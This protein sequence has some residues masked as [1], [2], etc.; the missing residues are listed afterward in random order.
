[1]KKMLMILGGVFLVLIIV[2]SGVL[3]W[4]QRSGS[5]HQAKFFEAVLSDDPKRVVVLF[6]PALCE[7]VD[8]PILAAWM[9]AF[10]RN[11]GALK[12]LSKT[13]F[14]TTSKI[15]NGATV[16][17]SKGTV[18][19]EKG[20]ATSELKTRN[21]K[22]VRFHVKSDKMPEN[23][24]TGPAGTQLYGQRGKDFFTYFLTDKPDEA[25]KMMHKNLQAK[26]PPDKLKVM[27]ADFAGKAGKLKSIA[28]KS[29]TLISGDT[30]ALKVVYTVESEKQKSTGTIKF[31]FDGLKGHL[32]AFNLE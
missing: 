27:M 15:E 28:Y 12:G 19:F 6:D 18:K 4:A 10:K 1:M 29:E 13:D 11:L 2:C 16:T 7:E 21:D 17:E 31:Q 24:F 30:P 25:F 8:E 3:V 14:E 9:V 26:V 20:Q 32:V 22:I 23:W 5:S